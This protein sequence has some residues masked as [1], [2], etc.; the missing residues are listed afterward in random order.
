MARTQEHLARNAGADALAQRLADTLRYVVSQRL[1]PKV[2]GGRVLVSEAMGSS[3]RTREAVLLG[4][5]EVRDFH[6]IV[7]AGQVN[8]W[9]SF[10][11]SLLK[12]YE[13]DLITEETALL[14]CVNKTQMRRRLDLVNK[15]RAA[16]PMTVTMKMKP[17]EPL[18]KPPP[19]PP[20]PAP[21]LFDEDGE[22]TDEE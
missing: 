16:E 13:D 4:E 10:E 14:Y 15:R 17:A 21:I 8:G 9:H 1:A 11:Q 18:P 2:G 7:E 5:S 12:A 20:K 3:L 6:E 22:E 19:P